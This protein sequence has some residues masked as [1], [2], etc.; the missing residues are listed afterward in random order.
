MFSFF[1]LTVDIINKRGTAVG[2]LL[3]T[4]AP[5]FH[6]LLT[7]LFFTCSCQPVFEL[8][9]RGIVN[10]S[11]VYFL[12]FLFFIFCIQLWLTR[13]KKMVAGPSDRRLS[14][15][16]TI[17][18][19]W[20]G[21]LV[22]ECWRCHTHSSLRHHYAVIFLLWFSLSSFLLPFLPFP[23]LSFPFLSER[24]VPPA[25]AS[26]VPLHWLFLRLI[27][28]RHG[29]GTCMLNSCCSIVQIVMLLEIACAFSVNKVHV[30]ISE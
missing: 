29:S 10:V 24:S 7:F 30:V 5:S 8:T 20:H 11:N 6:L 22:W 14:Q 19:A 18:D 28:P 13:D 9:C 23:L 26:L 1:L 16:L 25:C 3:L 2:T 27:F 17:H 21:N 4:W 12:I 15:S